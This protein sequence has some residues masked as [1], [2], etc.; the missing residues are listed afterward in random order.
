MTGELCFVSK[1]WIALGVGARD[2]LNVIVVL[3]YQ[4]Q[5]KAQNRDLTTS[6]DHRYW[7]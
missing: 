5:E 4:F 1:A 3:D 7:R 6:N 2:T